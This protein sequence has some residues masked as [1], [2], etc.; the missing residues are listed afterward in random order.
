ME[1]PSEKARKQYLQEH[2]GANPKN[3]TVGE[4]GDSRGRDPKTE[5]RVNSKGEAAPKEKGVPID[6]VLENF[7]KSLK[8][9]EENLTSTQDSIQAKF[10]KSPPF[11]AEGAKL[12]F[13]DAG[14]ATYERP[15]GTKV[16]YNPSGGIGRQLL[17]LSHKVREQKKIVTEY[18]KK[19][20]SWLGKGAGKVGYPTGGASNTLRSKMIRLA[21]SMPKGSSERKALLN[22]LAT[23]RVSPESE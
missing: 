5:G 6:K 2:P 10:K 11:G 7:S 20:E 22:V 16:T 18:T 14:E 13:N 3:H 4:K 1:H 17:N 8:Q 19:V 15:G 9:S 12:T 21:A 23:P